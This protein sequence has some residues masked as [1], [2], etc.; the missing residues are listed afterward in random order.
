[1]RARK[2]GRHL[3]P[4]AAAIALA[5]PASAS[6][7]LF[8]DY[9]DAGEPGPAGNVLAVTSIEAGDFDLEGP[10]TVPRV[11]ASPQTGRITVR[12]GNGI[13]ACAGQQATV[14]NVDSLRLVASDYNPLILDVGPAPFAPGVTGEGNRSPEIEVSFVS[15]GGYL[16]IR[17]GHGPNRMLAAP[18][19]DEGVLG[20]NLNPRLDR[21]DDDSDVVLAPG[22]ALGLLGGPGADRIRVEETRDELFE[23]FGRAY[24]VGGRGDDVLVRSGGGFTHGGAGD[25]LIRGGDGFNISLGRDGRDTILAGRDRDIIEGG[26]GADELRSGA[27][28][29]F[30][31]ARDRARDR[32]DCG[33]GRD[34][35]ASYDLPDGHHSCERRD[36]GEPHGLGALDPVAISKAD[37]GARQA[38]PGAR[39]QRALGIASHFPR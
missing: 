17:G 14:D 15:A 5:A 11:Q 21:R 33:P 37:P 32:V 4:L 34:R 38:A 39:V 1:M 18:E 20:V 31:L 24:L 28:R 2:L 23:P 25:D 12:A 3:V 16:V 27:Q 7:D 30:V 22:A 13:V 29:D 35:L 19:G 6:A 8:C 36:R 9:V 10:E 26:A